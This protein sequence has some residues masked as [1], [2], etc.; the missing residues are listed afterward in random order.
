MGE[1]VTAN[2]SIKKSDVTR[3]EIPFTET[4]PRRAKRWALLLLPGLLGTALVTAAVIHIATAWSASHYS[5]YAAEGAESYHFRLNHRNKLLLQE[6]WGLL[7]LSDTIPQSLEST[8]ANAEGVLSLH[9]KDGEIVAGSYLKDGDTVF[10]GDTSQLSKERRLRLINPSFYSKGNSNEVSKLRLTKNHLTVH[11][12]STPFIETEVLLPAESQINHVYNQSGLNSSDPLADSR[13]ILGTYK[14][15][16]FYHVTI[17]GTDRNSIEQLLVRTLSTYSLS[18]SVETIDYTYRTREVTAE[19]VAE[20]ERAENSDL[21]ELRLINKTTGESSTVAHAIVS[22][23]TAIITNLPLDQANYQPYDLV[24]SCL[25]RAH[26]Y[27][28]KPLN[29][30]SRSAFLSEALSSPTAQ[31]KSK[32]RYCF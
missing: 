12:E 19:S 8:L 1:T 25:T 7:A 24:N 6:R 14:D 23:E 26:S 28:T 21:I 4:K 20:L 18:T 32:I 2:H 9:F 15:A 13:I 30:T 29:D 10:F 5:I 22:V 16:P 27:T 17:M 31:S 11:L 3:V